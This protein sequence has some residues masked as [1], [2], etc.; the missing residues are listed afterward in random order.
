MGAKFYEEDVFSKYSLSRHLTVLGFSRYVFDGGCK[1]AS[2]MGQGSFG[3]VY[4]AKDT[5]TGMLV[6]LK[7]IDLSK[8]SNSGLTYIL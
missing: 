7:E 1:E 8:M 4:R 3:K 5:A 6:A 2:I